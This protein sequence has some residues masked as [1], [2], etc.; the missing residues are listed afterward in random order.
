M[1]KLFFDLFFSDESIPSSIVA[2]CKHNAVTADPVTYVISIMLSC[3]VQIQ[4]VANGVQMFKGKDILFPYQCMN[5]RQREF[6]VK[7]MNDPD[8]IWCQY[9]N[10]LAL[11]K[12]SI[13]M[14]DHLTILHA[15]CNLI[16]ASKKYPL[17]QSKLAITNIILQRIHSNVGISKPIQASLNACLYNKNHAIPTISV[18]NNTEQAVL[19]GASGVEPTAGEQE[20]PDEFG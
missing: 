17:H 5:A 1:D 13:P 3:Q 18:V 9:E 12:Q 16:Q 6:I 19:N 15:L 14:I 8:Q 4:L 7:L 20:I 10:C 2:L 11:K